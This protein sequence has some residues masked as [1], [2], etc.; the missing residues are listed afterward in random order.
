[1]SNRRHVGFFH[2]SSR[3]DRLVRLAHLI[4]DAISTLSI[5]KDCAAPLSVIQAGV[6]NC[7]KV[8]SLGR[9]SHHHALL[10]GY[11]SNDSYLCRM[12]ITHLCL[13]RRQSIATAAMFI[14]SPAFA[15][16]DPWASVAE[17]ARAMDQCHAIMIRQ[18][19]K[20]VLAE[21]FRGPG[22]NRLAPVK[23]VS[24]TIV[25][26]LSGAAIAREEIPSMQSRLGDLAPR[27]IPSGADPRVATL[28]VEDLVTMQ[29]GLERTS[30]GNYGAWISS[31]DWVADALSRP[32]VGQP[33]NGMLYSTGSYHVLGALLSEVSGS[34]LLDLARQRLGNPLDIEIPAWT[35]DP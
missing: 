32:I 28:T 15:A 25:A 31:R 6:I 13:T 26:A 24:K 2:L 22:L 1:M 33:G 8:A 21:A 5:T 23:S 3:T 20:D 12:T 19:G 11:G 27:L 16:T 4:V 14:A 34:S 9:F 10:N 17:K 7:K 30:G 18:N 35:R 29:T